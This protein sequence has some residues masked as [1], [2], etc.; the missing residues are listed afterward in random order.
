MQPAGMTKN[1]L[2][3]KLGVPASRIGD[4]TLG[5]RGITGDTAIRLSRHFGTTEDY[6]L[7]LQ[8]AY[9]LAEARRKMEE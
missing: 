6:W 2:A 9:D 8:N 4:I 3:V 5:R 1:A 7:L